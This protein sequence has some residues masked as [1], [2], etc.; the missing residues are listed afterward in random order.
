[1]QQNYQYHKCKNVNLKIVSNS[2]SLEIL[3]KL[4]FAYNQ[5]SIKDF[6]IANYVVGL[7]IPFDINLQ[8]QLLQQ[9]QHL[10]KTKLWN[11]LVT[12]PS[13]LSMFN[14]LSSATWQHRYCQRKNTSSV[15]QQLY[16]TLQSNLLLS[17]QE[18]WFSVFHNSTMPGGY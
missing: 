13:R 15:E 18:L 8:Q 11:R 9:Q 7:Q 1:M 3:H 4:H 12:R 6:A 5:L 16:V 2:T 17:F 10:L 14:Y